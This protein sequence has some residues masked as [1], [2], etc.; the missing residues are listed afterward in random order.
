MDIAHKQTDKL[1]ETTEKQVLSIYNKVYAD[2]KKELSKVND[3]IDN[4]PTD[5]TMQQRINEWNKR[6]RLK[7]LEK[8]VSIAISNA[9]KEAQKIINGMHNQTYLNNF[10]YSSYVIETESGKIGVMPILDKKIIE[11]YI[12][13]G[14]SPFTKIAIDDLKD[15]NII[16]SQIARELTSG[17]AIGESVQKLAQR[18]KKTV[19]KSYSSSVRIARTETTRIEASARQKTYDIGKEKGIEM[20][21]EWVSTLDGDTRDNH[22][23]LDGQIVGIDEYFKIGGSKAMYPAD[24]G[25][26]SEDINCRCTT[27]PI[28]KGYTKERMTY[29]EWEKDR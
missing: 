6:D 3:K 22:R 29:A 24:F 5:A 7:T 4:L 27:R 19:N 20:Q 15:K 18:V 9:N 10:N 25:V 26:A 13:D 16:Y 14:I 12:Q 2:L 1:L 21:K 11:Q 23:K 17:I 28:L 8:Q